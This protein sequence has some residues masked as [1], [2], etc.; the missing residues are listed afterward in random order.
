MTGK[1][2]PRMQTHPL[3]R[4]TVLAA[5]LAT[6]TG[7]NTATVD[8]L[9]DLG[10]HTF[11][12]ATKIPAAQRQFDRGLMWCYAFHHDEARRCFSAAT[13]ADPD[14]AMGYW[15]LAY[16]AGPHINNMEMS[17]AAAEFAHGNATRAATLASTRPPIERA[18]IHAIG[19][20]Y[21]WPAPKERTALD[22]AYADAM[23][24]AYHVHGDHPDVAALYAESLMDLQPW[25]LWN[26]DGSPKGRTPEILAV[27]E[28]LLAAHPRH[29][30]GCHL[31]IHATEASPQPERALPSADRLGDLVP[32]AGHLVHMPSHAYI[33]VGRYDDAAEAN[34]VAIAA[35]LAIVARTGRE[36]FYE[37]YRAHNYHFLV[38]AC[39]FLG[40]AEEAIANARATVRELPPEVV[41]AMPLFLD[42]FMAVPTHALVRFGRWEEVLREPEPAEWL[43]VTRAF[44]HYGRG[45]AAAALD[46]L[47]DAKAEQ[48]AFAA[49]LAAVPEA[50]MMG[51]NPARTVLGV[52]EAMLAGELAFRAGDHAAAFQALEQAVVRDD[53]LRY[54][55]PWGWMMPA[56][57]ALGALLLEAG[58]VAA[59][60]AVYRKDLERHTDNGWAL[61]GLEECLRLRGS[62]TEA[63]AVQARF[64]RAWRHA[65]IKIASSCFCRRG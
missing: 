51:N 9:Q 24:A 38:Y 52:G 21:A 12:V 10:R 43:P 37:L 5:V 25:D 3:C 16:A 28:K 8:V 14:F 33:R 44:W 26:D 47:D 6:L 39:M 19:Q 54:D 34:R 48:V 11:P 4:T 63:D 55:E 57:H 41:K 13:A 17:E 61:R 49:A 18:L 64:E 1:R 53:A 46:R 15:G 60:E 23:G 35:D 32:A 30:Q 65:D 58:R 2:D 27:L 62:T 59:A 20:R 31:Y 22:A 56:R 42:G 29:P 7:C 36:G 40:R 50:A 45:V